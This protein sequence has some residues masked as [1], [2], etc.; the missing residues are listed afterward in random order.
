MIRFHEL[1][2]KAREYR[3][4]A[5][6]VTDHGNMFGAVEFYQQAQRHGIK[7]IIGAELYVAP[8]RLD[9]RTP[10]GGDQ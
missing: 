6:A 9:D 2:E 1:L 10:T 7:P 4:P 3:M 5:V 8:G